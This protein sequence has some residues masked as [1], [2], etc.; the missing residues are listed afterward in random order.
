MR[1]VRRG[2]ENPVRGL[3]GVADLDD[4]PWF[5][6]GHV[7]GL[8]RGDRAAVRRAGPLQRGQHPLQRPRSSGWV[9]PVPT[10]PWA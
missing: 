1:L 7:P 2:A 10:R 3:L 4:E 6:P 8:G 9:K 5:H